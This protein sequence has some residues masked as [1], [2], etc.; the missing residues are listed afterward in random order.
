MELTSDTLSTHFMFTVPSDAPAVFS[1]PLVAL[2]WVVRFQFTATKRGTPAGAVK[3][4][5]L[6]WPM[7]LIVAAPDM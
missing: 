7:P 3:I 5:Q 2:S 6:T 4:D 1:T